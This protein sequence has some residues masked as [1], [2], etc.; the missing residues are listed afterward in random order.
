[1]KFLANENF[2]YLSIFL[3]REARIDVVSIGETYPGIT[4]EQVMQ[5]AINEHRTIVTF[6][7]DY[8]ELLYKYGFRP[9]EGVIYLRLR[10]FQPHEPA[11]LIL[12]MINSAEFVFHGH[13]TVID[14]E[15]VRQR[16]IM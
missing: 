8:G 5:I 4:D 7:K 12:N 3:L 1:M 10:D 13:F 2:P 14:F 9:P 6:D 15:S 11:N 16:R